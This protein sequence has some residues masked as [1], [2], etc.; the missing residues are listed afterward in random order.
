[1][2]NQR[3]ID[4]NRTLIVS[5]RKFL[6]SIWILNLLIVILL[7][8]TIIAIIFEIFNMN[9]ANIVVG[10]GISIACI[11]GEFYSSRAIGKLRW[12]IDYLKNQIEEI[13]KEQ[14]HPQNWI[15]IK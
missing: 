1:M 5:K 2:N 8:L 9:L 11:V 10:I 6:K 12:E 7:V 13:E 15:R 3:I 4:Y 14:S